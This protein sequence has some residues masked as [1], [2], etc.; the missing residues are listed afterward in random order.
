MLGLARE[1]RGKPKER[2]VSKSNQISEF[3]VRLGKIRFDIAKDVEHDR[4]RCVSDRVEACKLRQRSGKVSNE[5][6]EYRPLAPVCI[7]S[8]CKRFTFHQSKIPSITIGG[9]GHECRVVFRTIQNNFV[10]GIVPT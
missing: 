10:E 1:S 9:K 7:A 8:C 6:N 2:M 4:P 3:V 5:S